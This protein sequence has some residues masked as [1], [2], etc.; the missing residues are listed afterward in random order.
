MMGLCKTRAAVL[1]LSSTMFKLQFIIHAYTCLFL[2]IVCGLKDA[3]RCVSTAS[4]LIAISRQ[5]SRVAPCRTHY[6]NQDEMS[7]KHD[8]QL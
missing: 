3:C 4:A 1:K 5:P 6:S 2:C 7:P 8:D